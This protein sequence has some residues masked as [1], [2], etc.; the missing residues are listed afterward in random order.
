MSATTFDNKNLN[1]PESEALTAGVEPL[2]RV[3]G[4]LSIIQALLWAFLLYR[5]MTFSSMGWDAFEFEDALAT[6]PPLVPY[7]VYPILAAVDLVIGVG[8][9]RGVGIAR[10]A[11][12]GRSVLVILL[13]VGYWALTSEF[14][15]ATFLVA[16]AG[17]LLLCLTRQSAWVVNYPAAFWLIVFFVIPNFIVLLISLSE[18]GPLGTIVYPQLSVEG[19]GSLFN[20]YARFFSRIGGQLIYLQIFWRS[21]VLALSNTA[22]CLLIG[23]PF[24]YWIARR[25]QKWRNILIFLVMI[26]FWTNFLV[27]TYAWMLLLR[28]S[29]L[30]NNFWTTTL[31][32]QAVALAGSSGFFAWLATISA[33]PLPLLFNNGAVLLGLFY[34]YFPFVVLP[35]Y[36]NLEQLDWSLL[37]AASDLGA[38]SW[39]STTRILLPLSLPGIVAAGIIVF[40]PSLGAYVT[41]ALMGGGKVSLLGNLLQQ[42]FMTARDWPFGSAI[43]FLMMAVMLI[44]ILIYFR[45]AGVRAAEA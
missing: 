2:M 19:I 37:E 1:Q 24:A 43:G 5:W 40:V 41:P 23:Y 34:G 4:W 21:L 8:L 28:D 7:I 22:I 14:F 3:A 15:G 27:R 25:P 10:L 12:I 31:H 17:L 6:L 11:G 35:L 20:D 36:S 32:E 9:L 18:R 26:P 30:I 13:A 38:S 33:A 42:Q 44:S 39:Q 45:V 16:L 29:G